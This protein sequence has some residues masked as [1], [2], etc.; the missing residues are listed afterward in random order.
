MA[1]IRFL[2]ELFREDKKKT[3]LNGLYVDTYYPKTLGNRIK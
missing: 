2:I 1:L 3:E